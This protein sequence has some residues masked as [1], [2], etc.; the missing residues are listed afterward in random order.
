MK[1]LR[2]TPSWADF[3]TQYLE[4]PAD[5]TSLHLVTLF[6]AKS[7]SNIFVFVLKAHGVHLRKTQP[8]PGIPLK[9]HARKAR[10]FFLFFFLNH[11]TVNIYTIIKIVSTTIFSLLSFNTFL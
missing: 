4:V 5:I 11:G 3:H 6:Q 9:Y 2:G 7:H 8:F 1:E 10:H